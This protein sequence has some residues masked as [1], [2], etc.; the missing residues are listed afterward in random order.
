MITIWCDDGANDPKKLDSFLSEWNL[1]R[2]EVLTAVD[3]E[4]VIAQIRAN[5]DVGLIVI[6][7]LWHSEPEHVAVI[8]TGVHYI[9]RLRQEFPKTKIVTRSVIS[10]PEVLANLVQVF[11]RLGVSDHFVSHD[12]TPQAAL[13]RRLALELAKKDCQSRST[14]PPQVLSDFL[15]PRWAAILFADISGFTVMT[16][17]LWFRN[18]SLLSTTIKRF[19]DMAVSTVSEHQGIVDKLIGDEVMGIFLGADNN[20]SEACCRAVNAA[21][22]I[23]NRFREIETFFSGQIDEEDEEFRE[24][25][26]K[27]KIGIEAGSVDIS[28]VNLPGNEREICTIG[29]AVNI[30]SRIKAL[31][32][33]YAVSLGPTLKRELPGK[34]IYEVEPITNEM[35]LKGL[36]TGLRV[37][38]LKN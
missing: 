14:Q 3:D 22:G 9:E 17:Q 37:Y 35:A 32:G 4:S 12:R 11:V 21:R 2:E 25:K 23:L 13:R 20:K 15:G 7:L 6:D 5:K 33:D 19:Y 8:P 36:E 24:V 18:R 30:A 1:K 38:T 34:R 10:A 28:Q 31:A 16:D 26:W 27:L 29:R